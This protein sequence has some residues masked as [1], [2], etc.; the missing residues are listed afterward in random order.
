MN[1]QSNPFAAIELLKAEIES[2]HTEI[3]HLC[4]YIDSHITKTAKC[5]PTEPED[6]AVLTSMNAF[7]HKSIAKICSDVDAYVSKQHCPLKLLQPITEDT[8]HAIQ[9]ELSQNFAMWLENT[10]I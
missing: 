2:L 4:G 6:T 1:D 7:Y 9:H 5:V 8:M 10:T 3:A